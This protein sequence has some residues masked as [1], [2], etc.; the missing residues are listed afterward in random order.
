MILPYIHF[1]GQC[2]EALSFYAMVLGGTPAFT[3]Y[4]EM[5]DAPGAMA[6]SDRVMHGQLETDG[7]GLLMGS[8]FPEGMAGDPQ[9]AVSITIAT[10]TAEEA[11]RLYDAFAEGGDM[12]QPFDATFFSPGFGMMRDRFGTHWMLMAQGGPT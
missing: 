8:D 6:R 11:R 12:I 3:P 7:H 4:S 5:P 10:E 9:K 2:R 1:Q